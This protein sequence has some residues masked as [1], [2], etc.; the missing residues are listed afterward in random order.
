MN[1]MFVSAVDAQELTEEIPGFGCSCAIAAAAPE[2]GSA[3]IVV[4]A[5]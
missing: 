2:G 1:E 5:V 4:D 3:V